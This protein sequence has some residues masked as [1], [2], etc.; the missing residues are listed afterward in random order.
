MITANIF[1][2]LSYDIKVM[3]LT[4]LCAITC[5]VQAQ[6]SDLIGATEKQIREMIPGYEKFQ[7]YRDDHEIVDVMKFENTEGNL[8]YYFRFFAGIDKCYQ[9][10]IFGPLS[11]MNNYRDK[12]TGEFVLLGENYWRNKSRTAAAVSF[13]RDDRMQILLFYTNPAKE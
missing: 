13:T 12:L 3:T 2:I 7:K 5:G 1:Y 4:L 10:R 11:L 6:Y 9:V 8:S